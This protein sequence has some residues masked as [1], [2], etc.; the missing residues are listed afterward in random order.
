MSSGCPIVKFPV[1]AIL[2]PF[3]AVAGDVAFLSALPADDWWPHDPGRCGPL[4]VN[5]RL[6]QC[7]QGKDS[8]TDAL[9][10]PARWNEQ[11]LWV[12]HD[13]RPLRPKP[14]ETGVE[15]S[16]IV[17]AI[18]VDGHPLGRLAGVA[19]QTCTVGSY[20]PTLFEVVTVFLPLPGRGRGLEVR[21]LVAGCSSITPLVGGPR[22]RPDRVDQG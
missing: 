16:M 15:A 21:S 17:V 18:T 20:D 22:Y 1:E 13:Q 11:G 12:I 2:I 6:G 10:Q 4:V 8:I 14:V 9:L 7:G 19:E 5:P 3:R